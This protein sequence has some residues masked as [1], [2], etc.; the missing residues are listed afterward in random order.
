MRVVSTREGLG[1]LIVVCVAASV[2]ALVPAQAL[3]GD[4]PPKPPEYGPVPSPPSPPPPA[5]QT[6]MQLKLKGE[7]GGKVRVGKRVRV[8][9]TLRPWQPGQQV[10]VT[11]ERGE[12]T[13]KKRI[14]EPTSAGGGVG[15][16][17][18]RSPTLVEPGRYEATAVHAVDPAKPTTASSPKFKVRYPSLNRGDRGKDVKL[19]NRLLDKQGYVPSNGRRFTTRTARAV[20]AYRKVHG[21][22]RTTRATS[23]IFKTLADGRGAYKLKHPGA[24]KHVEVSVGRQVMVLADDGKAQRTYAVSTGKASTPTVQGHFRFY[25]RQPGFNAVG[26]YYSVYFHRGYAIHGYRDVPARYPASH[27]CVRSP[28]PDAVS[29]YNWVQIGMSIYVY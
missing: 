10:T 29:I 21:M 14:V 15:E 16:F 2:A 1:P 25:R 27:G 11:L 17:K 24:G 9:G 7:K 28:I 19:L 26:M 23:G 18:F 22:A 6:S 13:V 4:K 5:G 20:L 3:A 8:L 12:R